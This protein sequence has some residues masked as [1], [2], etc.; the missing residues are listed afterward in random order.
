MSTVQKDATSDS[1]KPER[2]SQ[3]AV[4]PP[5]DKPKVNSRSGRQRYQKKVPKSDISTPK[6]QMRY[7]PKLMLEENPDEKTVLVKIGTRTSTRQV[8]NYGLTKIK[9]DWKVTFNAFRMEMTKALQATEI[10]KTRVPFLHQ[11]NRLISYTTA[12][13]TKPKE[14]TTE[15]N[16]EEEIK[17]GK[18]IERISSG[19]S[20]TLSR[21]QFEVQDLAGYQRPKPRQFMQPIPKSRPHPDERAHSEEAPKDL[22]KKKSRGGNNK[23]KNVRESHEASDGEEVEKVWA[24]KKR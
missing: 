9:D 19:I 12:I 22:R 17:E 6:P 14:E 15:D 2:T 24:T 10:I 20:I 5:E 23:K 7:L 1:G 11:E 21:I 3:E 18:E 13:P 8:I 16:A 4:S